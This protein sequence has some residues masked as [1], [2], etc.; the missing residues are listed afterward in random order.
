M[1]IRALADRRKMPW[2]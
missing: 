2:A 1:Q